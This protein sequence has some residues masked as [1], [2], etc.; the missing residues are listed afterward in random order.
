MFWLRNKKLVLNDTLLSG[1]MGTVYLI[2]NTLANCKYDYKKKMNG[3]VEYAKLL[4][5]HYWYEY[6]TQHKKTCH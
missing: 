4:F 6:G 1:G 5:I 2:P 3:R